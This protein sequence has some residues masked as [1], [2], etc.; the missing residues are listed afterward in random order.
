VSP[1]IVVLD[2]RQATDKASFLA[3]A[4]RDLEFPD[5]FGGNWDA[6]EECVRDFAADRKP[7]LVVWTG[8]A[9]VP[10]EVRDTAI[11]I[12]SAAF[13]TGADV[14]IVDDVQAAAQPNFSGAVERISIPEHGLAAAQQFWEVVGFSVDDT[15]CEADAIVIRLVP[16]DD[17]HPTVGPEI[18]A[19]DLPGLVHRLQAA[20]YALSQNPQ[21]IDVSD[22]H[23]TLITFVAY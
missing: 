12:F 21:G 17:F 22:P 11:E 18:A 1:D 4:A 10:E 16:V 3:A 23:G 8:A 9:A 15:T 6:F 5:Y 13:P 7:V 14:L 20:G 2:T 19:A